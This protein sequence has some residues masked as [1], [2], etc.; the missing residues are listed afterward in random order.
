MKN[1]PD[2]DTSV[3]LAIAAHPDDLEYCLA[4]SIA[5]WV[6][7]G[8][9]VYYVICTDGGKGSNDPSLTSKQLIQMRQQEQ[10]AAAKLLGVEKIFF[11]GYEDGFLEP[12][13][14]LKRD[15]VRIIRT[16]KPTVAVT[17]D[18][19]FDYSTKLGFYNH[20]DHRAS[21][22]AALDALY[23]LA[24]DRLA[25]PELADDGLQPHNTG[26]ALL[27]NFDTQDYFVDISDT[28]DTKLAAWRL[29]TS[30][31]GD[32]TAEVAITSMAKACGQA[33]GCECAE[34]FKLIRF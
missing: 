13:R 19:S 29:H 22:R 24:R 2:I 23:P 5:Q 17:W 30:Q 11:L 26:H 28:L 31:I 21:G 1:Q 4:G 18:P 8:S 6:K 9:K 7:Q 16:V 32:D 15:L 3:V 25:F 33:A 27:F 34:G 10:E 12:T 14:D 20:S